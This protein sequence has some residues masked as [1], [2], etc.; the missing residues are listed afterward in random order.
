[1]IDITHFFKKLNIFCSIIA[2]KAF[3]TL[4]LIVVC[5]LIFMNENDSKYQLSEIIDKNSDF[6]IFNV[7]SFF[8]N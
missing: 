4:I 5:F 8:L 2:E 1:M 6:R 7:S 3:N